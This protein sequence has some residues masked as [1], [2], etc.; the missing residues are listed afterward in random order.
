[1][2]RC[3]VTWTRNDAGTTDVDMGRPIFKRKYSTMYRFAVL[4]LILAIGRGANLLL[5]SPLVRTV[6]LCAKR[7]FADV[8]APLSRPGRSPEAFPSSGHQCI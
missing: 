2:P 6:S 7:V 4:F 3:P 5:C 1:M 8:S